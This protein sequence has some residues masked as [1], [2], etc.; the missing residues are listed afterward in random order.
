MVVC[1]RSLTVCVRCVIENKRTMKTST[2]KKGSGAPLLTG[3]ATP[4]K[5]STITTVAHLGTA[6]S[7]PA[8]FDDLP[9]VKEGG[10]DAECCEQGFLYAQYSGQRRTLCGGAH[11]A[12]EPQSRR[13]CQRRKRVAKQRQN[14]DEEDEDEDEKE[15][16]RGAAAAAAAAGTGTGER[17]SPFAN[18]VTMLYR[19][20]PSGNCINIKVFH[21]GSVQM[22]GARTIHDS[23]RALSHLA[24]TLGELAAPVAQHP[25]LLLAQGFRVCLINSDFHLG[26]AVLRDRLY[27]AIREHG[28]GIG[29]VYEP[30]IYP[31]VKMQ[32][33]WNGAA[34][35]AAAGSAGSAAGGGIDVDVD[36]L[37]PGTCACAVPCDG[38]GDGQGEGR[39]RRITISIFQSGSALITGAHTMEQLDAAY[40]FV[41]RFVREHEDYIRMPL[42]PLAAAAAAAAAAPCS[43]TDARRL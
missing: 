34:A 42:D 4:Y 19:H 22:T 10:D 39:C 14:D 41:V 3:V 6:L 24:K 27:R 12:P 1:N 28:N 25:A 11:P 35:A 9:L 7:L 31:G 18:Q 16:E 36:G 13:A 29:V 15:K 26:V 21:N 20:A 8:V 37:A 38:L 23:H 17:R 33:M 40:A 30:C 5:I 2:R 32:Y 43:A